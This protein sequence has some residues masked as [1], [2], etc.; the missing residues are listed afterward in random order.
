MATA[1]RVD[2]ID[3]G[4]SHTLIASGS[5]RPP[6]APG[7]FRAATT[8]SGR[9][10]PGRFVGNVC[11][12]R[13]GHDR[14]LKDIMRGDPGGWRGHARKLGIPG[15]DL[16][17]VVGRRASLVVT[18]PS[19]F[20]TISPRA[21]RRKRGDRHWQC[22][23]RVG[24]HPVEDRAELRDGH[25]AHAHRR[26]H[27]RRIRTNNHRRGR[28][29]PRSHDSP[30][31]WASLATR[32]RVPTSEPAIAAGG[33]PTARRPRRAKS[34][35]ICVTA[36]PTGD[37]K[38][39]TNRRSISSA[40]VVARGPR[41][42]PSGCRCDTTAGRPGPERG[43]PQDLLPSRPTDSSRI[44]YHTQRITGGA[45]CERGGKFDK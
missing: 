29:P 14:R 41:R 24:A 32:C 27:P 15:E 26:D 42:A 23:A 43:H 30:K 12:G 25:V 34:V 39:K 40:R 9:G 38:P 20:R 33:G 19:G 28:G 17:G 31:S 8:R 3:N 22:S 5:R 35:A 13:G 1:A 18:W 10:R 36:D 16:P 11:N 4:P 6:V 21:R 7:G 45:L 2:I 44:G 37:K